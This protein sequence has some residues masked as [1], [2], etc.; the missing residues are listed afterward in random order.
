[1][2]TIKEDSSA[3]ILNNDGSVEIHLQKHDE[4]IEK[5]NNVIISLLSVLITNED[6]EIW[7]FLDRKSKEIF[8]D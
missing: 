2:T 6:E 5:T 8:E 3:L 1:M 4:I 7:E